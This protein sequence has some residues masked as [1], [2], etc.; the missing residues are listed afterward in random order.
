MSLVGRLLNHDPPPPFASSLAWQTR[1][2]G[3]TFLLE[4]PTASLGISASW[5]QLWTTTSHLQI[6]LILH[7]WKR[8]SIPITRRGR[9]HSI[10]SPMLALLGKGETIQLQT[11][12]S[13]SRR[14]RHLIVQGNIL[15]RRS[16]FTSFMPLMTRTTLETGHDGRNGT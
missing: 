12:E 10:T 13:F 5:S 1:I 6:D 11:A 4:V 2:P 9:F 16:P 14:N 8:N 3:Y 15:T 7:D